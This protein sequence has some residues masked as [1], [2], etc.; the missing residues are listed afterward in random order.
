[1]SGSVFPLD[2]R[3]MD[4]RW[5]LCVDGETVWL[6]RSDAPDGAVS[7][8]ACPRCAPHEQN[9]PLPRLW[10]TVVNRVAAGLP[11]LPPRCGR[12]T[13]PMVTCHAELVSPNRPA[14]RGTS[15]AVKRPAGQS[16]RRKDPPMIENQPRR[17]TFLATRGTVVSVNPLTV[18]I[19]TANGP[20]VVPRRPA[21][22]PKDAVL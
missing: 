6:A 20:G 15:S 17:P 12:P 8:D 2:G 11:A 7:G 22:C 13:R 18:R 16:N 3:W 21:T 5:L 1:M 19:P 14:C 10:Q 4:E 9:G